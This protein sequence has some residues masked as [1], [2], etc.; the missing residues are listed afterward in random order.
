MGEIPARHRDEAARNYI[1][2]FLEERKNGDKILYPS[3]F[4]DQS[5]MNLLVALSLN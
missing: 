3:T 5:Q 2:R 1:R 4:T